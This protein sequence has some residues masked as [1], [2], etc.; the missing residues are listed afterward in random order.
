MLV[1]D[2][3]DSNPEMERVAMYL[4][5]V[6]PKISYI[7]IPTRPPTEK[8]VRAPPENVLANAGSIFRKYLDRVEVLSQ[9]GGTEFF[10]T[11]DP[12]EDILAI[13]SVHP[14]REDSM[15]EI[16]KRS[17]KDWDTV[18]MLLEKGELEEVEYNGFWYY[19]R[20]LG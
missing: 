19:V 2:M 9:F 1:S 4:K 8:W 12:A 14:L 11:G 20:K 15:K 5:R 3:N 10:V 16:L 13:S 17:G 18:S 6:N 7:T